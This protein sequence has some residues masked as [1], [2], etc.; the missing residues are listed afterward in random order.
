MNEKKFRELLRMM[1]IESLK[2]E[3]SND[4]VDEG[5]P[6]D[7]DIDVAQPNHELDNGKDWD[8]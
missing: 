5:H 3:D 7:A 4:D 2:D 8:R 1:I 6:P